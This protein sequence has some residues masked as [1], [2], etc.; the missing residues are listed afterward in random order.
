MTIKKGS[1]SLFITLIL[2]NNNTLPADKAIAATSQVATVVANM[3]SKLNAGPLGKIALVLAPLG[4]VGTMNFLEERWKDN[5]FLADAAKALSM[6]SLLACVNILYLNNDVIKNIINDSVK[7][8]IIFFLSQLANNEFIIKTIA[9]PIWSNLGHLFLT[10][11]ELDSKTTCVSFGAIARNV[12]PFFVIQ[13]A[14][15][16]YYFGSLD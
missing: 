10:K 4:I 14:L 3:A 15:E 7:V 8:G 12:L 13:K 6:I 9:S 1:I 16:K 5:P 11:Q 2:L